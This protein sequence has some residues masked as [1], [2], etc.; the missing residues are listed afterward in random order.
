MTITM[1]DKPDY[2]N[3][4]MARL[5][6]LEDVKVGPQGPDYSFQFTSAVWGPFMMGIKLPMD[7]I[8]ECV[9]RSE[10]HRDKDARH[11]L[12]G[13]LD[14]E[15]FFSP[16]D[17]DWFMEKMTFI[18]TAYRHA[19]E[20]HFQ[21]RDLLPKDENGQPTR[22][23][24]QLYLND[25]WINRMKEGEFN[26][27]HSHSGDLSFVIFCK[28]PDWQDEIENHKANSTSPGTLNFMLE[29]GQRGD[30]KW[31][32]TQHPVFPEVGGMWIFPAELNHE[33]YPYKTPGERITISGNLTYANKKDF[34]ARYF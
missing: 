11:A 29:L 18:F 14:K 15:F 3:K 22:F 19:H 32:E 20:D 13:H 28:N 17:R 4:A 21:L 2:F 10:A 34:P 27:P 23:P 7:F 8:N 30:S 5:Q 26:P 25:L 33:V 1:K 31:K 24:V 16:E 6:H 12:A 9:A